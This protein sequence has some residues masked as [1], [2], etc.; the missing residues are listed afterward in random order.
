MSKDLVV[1]RKREEGKVLAFTLTKCNDEY[2]S[3]CGIQD[4]REGPYE[5]YIDRSYHYRLISAKVKRPLQYFFYSME[6]FALLTVYWKRME[7][8][9]ISRHVIQGANTWLQNPS[10]VYK[11]QRYQKIRRKVVKSFDNETSLQKLR[12]LNNIFPL[13]NCIFNFRLC[14]KS[15]LNCM[16]FR[17]AAWRE[18][19]SSRNCLDTRIKSQHQQQR[20]KTI[21]IPFR[22]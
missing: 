10:Q 6:V 9:Q 21:V 12:Y 5:S 17:K 1:L 8:K 13:L 19:F 22:R 11:I 15:L 18:Y 7:N 4:G 14:L 2:H 3:N 20:I 16:F